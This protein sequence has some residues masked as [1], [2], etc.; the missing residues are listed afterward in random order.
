[1]QDK[2]QPRK[3]QVQVAVALDELKPAEATHE[4]AEP[5]ARGYDDIRK[6]V[7]PSSIKDRPV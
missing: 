6:N 3:L 7:P 2:P 4:P 1:M 5:A